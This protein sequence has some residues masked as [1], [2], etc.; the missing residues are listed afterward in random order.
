MIQY[1]LADENREAIQA[2]NEMLVI[3]TIKQ[4]GRASFVTHDFNREEEF[5][6]LDALVG[7]ADTLT[8]QAIA[9]MVYGTDDDPLKSRVRSHLK[10]GSAYQK[11]L[12]NGT[13]VL[14]RQDGSLRVT[15]TAQQFGDLVEENTAQ[16]VARVG[17][18]V[19]QAAARLNRNIAGAVDKV[20]E[21]AERLGQTRQ[22]ARSSLSTIFSRQLELLSGVD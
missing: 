18:S 8:V 22:D 16:E 5:R 14:A 12:R 20:P 2:H 19:R 17:K 11:T 13:A 1:L 21:L 9:K 6:Q 4:T 7:E 10:Y 3:T 15:R